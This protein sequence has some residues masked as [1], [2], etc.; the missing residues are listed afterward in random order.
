[1]VEWR[2]KCLP[3][4]GIQKGTDSYRWFVAPLSAADV[5]ENDFCLH[6][7]ILRDKT[8][9]NPEVILDLYM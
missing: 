6:L 3:P 2:E 5:T 9:R 7:S 1:P 8:G 4:V